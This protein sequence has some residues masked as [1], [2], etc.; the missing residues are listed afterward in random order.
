MGVQSNETAM[1]AFLAWAGMVSVR[2]VDMNQSMERGWPLKDQQASK[3]AVSRRLICFWL[4][5]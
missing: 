3:M 1:M 5:V 4:M 2:N